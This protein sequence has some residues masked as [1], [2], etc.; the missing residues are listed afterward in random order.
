MAF[1]GDLHKDIAPEPPSH[2]LANIENEKAANLI[3]QAIGGTLQS[4]STRPTTVTSRKGDTWV[5]NDGTEKRRAVNDRTSSQMSE[6]AY[7]YNTFKESINSGILRRNTL[8]AGESVN[9][10]IYFPVQGLSKFL[11]ASLFNLR[12][13][14]FGDSEERVYSLVISMPWGIEKVRFTKEAGE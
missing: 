9:G 4:L 6:T 7:L 11:D 2:I 12:E 10:Y 5:V 1:A 14:K 8:F 3:V 13:R